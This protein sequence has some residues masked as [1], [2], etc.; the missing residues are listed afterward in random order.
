MFRTKKLR[1]MKLWNSRTLNPDFRAILISNWV[2]NLLNKFNYL[3]G[4]SR[5]EK[6]IN[7]LNR[8]IIFSFIT[9]KNKTT[10]VPTKFILLLQGT[11]AIKNY[12]LQMVESLMVEY[13]NNLF[14]LDF[15][16]RLFR[17][18]ITS[19]MFSKSIVNSKKSLMWSIRNQVQEASSFLKHRS[20]KPKNKFKN[21]LG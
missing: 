2:E 12:Q 15:R 11:I 17:G 5:V 20:Y 6:T 13:E 1:L 16:E 19:Q 21:L 8:L 4:V 18:S 7:S 14:T 10:G 3:T 9:L